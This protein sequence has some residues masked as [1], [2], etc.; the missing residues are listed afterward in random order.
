MP[1]VSFAA[2]I[3]P[4]FDKTTDV[5]HMT[6]QRDH[7]CPQGRLVLGQPPGLRSSK[8]GWPVGIFRRALLRTLY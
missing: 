1:G 6:A 5:P 7:S 2:D 4:L 3:L 8:R